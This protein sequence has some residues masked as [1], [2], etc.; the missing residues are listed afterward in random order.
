MQDV[1]SID[2]KHQGALRL[3][4]EVDLSTAPQLTRALQTTVSSGGDLVVD[5]ACVSFMDSEGLRPLLLAA[6]LLHGRGRLVF[7][8][9]SV[10]VSRLF[11]L[12]GADAFPNVEIDE[13]PLVSWHGE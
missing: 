7:R 1:L 5:V 10:R 2:Q 4:G 8:A 3:S 9:P 12:V 11:A 13:R 6:R